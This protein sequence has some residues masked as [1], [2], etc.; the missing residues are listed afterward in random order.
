MS[1]EHSML[2]VINRVIENE[3]CALCEQNARKSDVKPEGTIA[4]INTIKLITLNQS[5]LSY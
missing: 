2:L 3:N 4:T 5:F 1:S